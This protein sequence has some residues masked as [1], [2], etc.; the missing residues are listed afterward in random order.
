MSLT[1]ITTH[2]LPELNLINLDATEFVLE[3]LVELE[4]VCILHLLSLWGLE[5]H[6]C[7][8]QRQ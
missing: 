2:R 4:G 8:A 5:Q 6:S 3:V 7:L 1:K